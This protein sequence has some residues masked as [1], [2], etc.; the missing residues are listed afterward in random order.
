[1]HP[2]N[3]AFSLLCS[4]A[5]ATSAGACKSAE[6]TN[7]ETSP[8]GAS[9]SSSVTTS[10]AG[11]A[12]GAVASSGSGASTTTTSAT[13]GGSGGS[14][15]T[16]AAIE[17]AL[18]AAAEG[19]LYTS[20]SDYPFEVVTGSVADGAPVDEA[21]VRAEFASYVD[22][23]ADADKPLASLFAMSKTWNEWKA[24]AHH[25]ADPNDP[26]EVAQ[27]KKMKALEAALEGSLT[28]VNVFYFGS[29]G[30]PGS[31]DGTGVSIFLVGRTPS[32]K[33]VG[34]ATLAIWT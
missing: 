31:V 11:G 32:G 1:V 14:G 23:K 15:M 18:A 30:A 7:D 17:A 16:D 10:G 3:S 25:C 4:L 27:C 33:L 8:T 24:L 21:T 13:S 12:N 22:K 29:V 6:T 5:L 20:E 26:V 19:L 28:S 9:S 34:V 2:R